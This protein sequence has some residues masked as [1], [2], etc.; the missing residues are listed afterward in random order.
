MTYNIVTNY[1]ISQIFKNKS[2]YF[3]VNLGLASTMESN[4]GDRFLN[5]KDDFAYFYNTT[6]KGATVLGQGNIGNIKI[7]SDPYIKD[8]LIAMYWNKEEFIFEF[9]KQLVDEKGVDF[10]LGHLIK[11][12]EEE[13]EFRIQEEDKK[14]EESKQKVGNPDLVSINP[15]AVSY[16][17]LMAY[18][19]KQR[20]ERLK[21]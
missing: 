1:K 18:L 20:N 17:D 16:A 19:E 8:D 7:Y 4:N 3:R 6:Y 12:V 14:K 15:G 5:Q 13:H 10:Y 2:K 9:D 21:S 11:K